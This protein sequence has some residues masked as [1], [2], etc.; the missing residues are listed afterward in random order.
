MDRKQVQVGQVFQTV[1]SPSGR[2]WRVKAILNLAG[3]P[4]AQLVNTEEE[5]ENKTLSCLVLA[6]PSRYCRLEA[7][8]DSF[9]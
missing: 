5:G 6:D 8:I 3:I 9:V 2:A 4:H 7:P 1:G